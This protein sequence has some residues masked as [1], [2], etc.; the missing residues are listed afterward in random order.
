MGTAGAEPDCS[1]VHAA[2]L[3]AEPR[4]LL[5]DEPASGLNADESARLLELILSLQQAGISILLVE[6]NM[7]VVMRA[8]DTIVVLHHGEKIAEGTP[9]EICSDRAVISAYLGQD[10][11][12]DAVG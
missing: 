8:S 3:A 6:H 1:R 5:L 7:D 4:L 2:G 12:A 9:R 10:W 11:M